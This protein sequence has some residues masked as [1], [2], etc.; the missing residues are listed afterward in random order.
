MNSRPPIR[1]AE[2]AALVTAAYEVHDPVAEDIVE[3][4]ARLL[5]EALGRVRAAD[6]QTPVVL[7]GRVVEASSPVGAELRRLVGE[8]FGGTVLSARDG[9]GGAAWLAL[10]SIDA[11]A[12]TPAVRARL[13][14]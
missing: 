14:Q 3:S 12:A 4:A 13:V 2:L 6:E 8:R 10:A 7:A 11:G 5:A 1:I 9:L